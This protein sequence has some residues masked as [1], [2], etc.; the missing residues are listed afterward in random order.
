MGSGLLCVRIVVILGNAS[1]SVRRVLIAALAFV[2]AALL[3]WVGFRF[4]SAASRD[5]ASSTAG[6]TVLDILAF[7]LAALFAARRSLVARRAFALVGPPVAVVILAVGLSAL[8]DQPLRDA[9]GERAP[10]FVPLLDL[11]PGG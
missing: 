9:I 10:V 3:A 5:P 1:P 2:C 6:G 8:R 4:V 7:A 11:F